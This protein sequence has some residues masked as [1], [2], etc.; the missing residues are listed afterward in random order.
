MFLHHQK[1]GEEGMWNS[2][3]F[4][5]QRY[6][7]DKFS[8]VLDVT[9]NQN[10][11]KLENLLWGAQSMRLVQWHSTISLLQDVLHR[12]TQE[13]KFEKEVIFHYICDTNLIHLLFIKERKL[14]VT[15]VN[16]KKKLN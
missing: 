5:T 9:E 3:N 15:I 1:W 12:P 6:N 4:P 11:L 7:V 13:V 16:K 2:S 10:E 14:K 8:F